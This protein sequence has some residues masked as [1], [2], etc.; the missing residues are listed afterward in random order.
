MAHWSDQVNTTYIANVANRY[1][2]ENPFKVFNI[3]PLITSQKLAGY[4]ATYT[5]SDWLRIG[6]TSLYKR[7]GASESVG[8]DYTVGKQAYRCEQ[9]SF[10]KDIT[11]DD[12][13]EYDNP[14]DPVNDSIDF[15]VNR[16]QR[17]LLS[18]LISSFFAS[19]IWGTDV[20]Y[21]DSGYNKWDAKTSGVSDADPV[22]EVMSY[23]STIKSTTGY[24]A[25]KMII[26]F[27]VLKALK[28]NTKIMDRMKTTTDKTVTLALLANLFEVERIEVLDAVNEGGTDFMVNGKMLLCY[29]PPRPTKA[30]PSA[31]YNIG[32]VGESNGRTIGTRKILMP[33]KNDA[34]RIEADMYIDQVAVGTDLAVFCENMVS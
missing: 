15:V 2:I 18:E 28:S 24:Q 7:V 33:E 12:R 19:S 26:T 6:T 17:V 3:F 13:N 8:D 16:L 23:H 27:D 14:F 4:I 21:D 31:G 5:K 9:Y 25:N 34:V 30:A 11:K 22:D 1:M 10:H 29:T 20:D 32:Y